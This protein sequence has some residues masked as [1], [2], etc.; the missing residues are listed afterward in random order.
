MESMS[1]IWKK[2]SLTDSEGSKHSMKDEPIMGDYLLATKF[3]T[4]RVLNMEAI[5][6]TFKLVW[7]TRKG[8]EVRDMGNHLVL[9]SFSDESDVAKVM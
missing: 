5:E 6:K 1:A 2:L 8:F 9:F 3:Y 7:R 4:R